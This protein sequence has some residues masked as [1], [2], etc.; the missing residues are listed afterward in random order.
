MAGSRQP[1][2]VVL[3]N[4]R[5]HFTKEEIEERLNAEV[6]PCTDDLSAPSYLTAA[7]KRHFNKLA[8]QLD[9]L[10]ILGETDVETL[11]RY[12]SAQAQYEK[13][14]KDLRALINKKPKEKD[15]EEPARY[16][17]ALDAWIGMQTALAKLQDRYFKQA[18]TA[19]TA[20]GLTISA[21]CKLVVPKAEEAPKVNKFAKFG[22]G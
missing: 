2:R 1:T 3:A 8:D 16:Y 15:F 9:K 13:T 10:G 4:G 11:A 6:Q 12:V 20:L 19:A 17:D 18:H 22:A 7:E 21:R 5:K 14:T